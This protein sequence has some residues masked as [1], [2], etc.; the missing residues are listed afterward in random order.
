MAKILEKMNLYMCEYGCH[1]V[2]VDVDNGV[3]PFMIGCEF[4]G[5]P[6]RKPDPT[7][8]KNGKCIGTAKSNFYPKEIDDKYPMP[9]PTHEW[10]RPE[11]T[12]YMELKS[13]AEKEHVDNGGL[14]MRVRTDKKAK[15]HTDNPDYEVP[16]YK[17]FIPPAPTQFNP[18]EK[19]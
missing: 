17:S 5:T 4:T 16:N 15:L 8:M 6:N 12:E 14:L 13:S 9:V 1:N 10:Y 18:R 7:K 11:L 3:T 19:Q 2:T